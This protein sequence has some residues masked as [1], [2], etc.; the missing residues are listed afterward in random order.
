MMALPSGGF[1]FYNKNLV[2]FRIFSILAGSGGSILIGVAFLTTA[3]SIN[4]IHQNSIIVDY[5]AVAGYGVM[6]LAI[7]IETPM[8]QIKPV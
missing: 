7:A 3:R 6:M 1:A 2:M 4:Q 5:L 8:Y